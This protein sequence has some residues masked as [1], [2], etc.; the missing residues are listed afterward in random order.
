MH[1][2]CLHTLFGYPTRHLQ[3]SNEDSNA[4]T[5]HERIISQKKPFGIK[6]Y[7][8]IVSSQIKM[9]MIRLSSE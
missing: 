1:I 2:A 6:K 4:I 3:T 9:T 8:H 5:M 7:P